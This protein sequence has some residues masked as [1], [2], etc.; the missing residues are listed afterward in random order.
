MTSIPLHRDPTSRLTVLGSTPE[1]VTRR[2][3]PL[4]HPRIDLA[5]R[6]RDSISYSARRKA[7][8]GRNMNSN[9]FLF[10]SLDQVPLR[11][12]PGVWLVLDCSLKRIV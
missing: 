4:I 12:R 7:N 8:R 1:F 2:S 3:L 10:E 5:A 6:L 9:S 11:V